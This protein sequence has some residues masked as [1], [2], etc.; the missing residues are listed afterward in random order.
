MFLKQSSTAYRMT[1]TFAARILSGTPL[2]S[3]TAT[4]PFCSHVP[5]SDPYIRS[6]RLSREPEGGG[7]GGGLEAFL[8]GAPAKDSSVSD[9]PGV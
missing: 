4:P 8:R 3:C 5:T 1:L 7:G 6:V 2:V 9:A